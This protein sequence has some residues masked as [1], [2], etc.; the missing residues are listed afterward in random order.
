MELFEDAAAF[1]LHLIVLHP[2]ALD[3]MA[4]VEPQLLAL[5]AVG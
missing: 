3:S 2:I 5:D 4:R 1:E